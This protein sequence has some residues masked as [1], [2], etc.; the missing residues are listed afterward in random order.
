M[1]RGHSWLCTQESLLVVLKGPYGMPEPKSR[2]AVCKANTLLTSGETPGPPGLG[3]GGGL[4]FL[5]GGSHP[6]MH[7]GYSWLCTQKLLLAVLRGPYGM[8]GIKPGS[9]AC[10]ANALPTVLSLQPH[11][12]D[13]K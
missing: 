7:R 12:E 9:A 4:F 10:K 13:F 11:I 3:W 5:G 2:L 6:V 8:L 1:H